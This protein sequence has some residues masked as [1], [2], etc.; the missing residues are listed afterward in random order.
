MASETLAQACS[1][2]RKQICYCGKLLRFQN[3]VRLFDALAS[4]GPTSEPHQTH[5][6]NLEWLMKADACLERCC[7]YGMHFCDYGKRLLVARSC[8]RNIKFCRTHNCPTNFE[9]LGLLLVLRHF[10]YVAGP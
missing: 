2:N 5:S 1:D 6:R 4:M 8:V 3:A 9:E 7:D 10:P